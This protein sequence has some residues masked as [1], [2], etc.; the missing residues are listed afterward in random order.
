MV[1]S[2]GQPRAEDEHDTFAKAI[3]PKPLANEAELRLQ[4]ARP[5]RGHSAD[6]PAA[7][8]SR[9]APTG[10][11]CV[12]QQLRRPL[13]HTRECLTDRVSVT[14]EDSSGR[15]EQLQQ[16]SQSQQQQQVQGGRRGDE[17]EY[18]LPDPPVGQATPRYQ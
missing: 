17:P 5:A 6:Q 12:G 8:A 18:K 14:P 11:E 7:D 16:Q 15:F 1:R 10:G 9:L 13:C 3:G 4:I 2:I